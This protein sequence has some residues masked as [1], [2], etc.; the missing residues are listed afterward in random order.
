MNIA[1]LTFL[2]CIIFTLVIPMRPPKRPLPK[3]EEPAAQKPK[4]ELKTVKFESSDGQEFAL[5]YDPDD[6][7][8][9]PANILRTVYHLISDL[10]ADQT[11]PLPSLNAAHLNIILPLVNTASNFEIQMANELDPLKRENSN[12]KSQ[13]ELGKM[14]A[15][16]P[17]VKQNEQIDLI[18]LILDFNY[19]DSKYL[20]DFLINLVTQRI[21]LENDP[22]NLMRIFERLKVLPVDMQKA[23]VNQ[24]MTVENLPF[25]DI[26]NNSLK[27]IFTAEYAQAIPFLVDPNDR[28][29]VFSPWGSNDL[30]IIWLPDLTAKKLTFEK[31]IVAIDL[32]PNGQK[33]AIKLNDADTVYIYD[34]QH[35]E[36]ARISLNVPQFVSN[37][38]MSPSGRYL[39]CPTRNGVLIFDLMQP[40]H[41]PLV[42]KPIHQQANIT[43][44][45]FI[46]ERTIVGRQ[47]PNNALGI[48]SISETDLSLKSSIEISL[49]DYRMHDVSSKGLAIFGRQADKQVGVIDLNQI[50]TTGVVQL[51]HF[52]RPCP[53]PDVTFRIPAPFSADGALMIIAQKHGANEDLYEW[54]LQQNNVIPL[55]IV[56]PLTGPFSNNFYWLSKNNQ[57]LI[58]A[59]AFLT[60]TDLITKR[61]QSLQI[62]SVT[63][64][65]ISH[66]VSFILLCTNRDILYQQLFPGL[67]KQLTFLEVLL[68]IKLRKIGMGLLQNSYFQK[69]WND[70]GAKK[71]EMVTKYLQG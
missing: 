8:K 20:L 58:Q 14:I 4:A 43:R 42:L 24:I 61:G 13:A 2:F 66:D 69:L 56:N 55:Y 52:F 18:D 31:P 26:T 21:L 70:M 23:I 48:Y 67:A 19:L 45:Y 62:P 25:T 7:I 51:A 65:I 35:L 29:F 28:Y 44:V 32:S 68:V 17:L 41:A 60:I 59:S 11:I 34:M 10:G 36:Q 64:A 54:D 53:L 16:I 39:G 33:L 30:S 47:T 63:K 27:K 40:T 22:Q 1:K 5:T 15:R 50:P 12:R 37:F 49:A 3:Q 71:Q 38:T 6:R 57:F 9:A 46:N